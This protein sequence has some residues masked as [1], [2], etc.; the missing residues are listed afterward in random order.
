MF[1]LLNLYTH[2]EVFHVPELRDYIATRD[3]ERNTWPG[4]IINSFYSANN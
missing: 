3:T 2:S 1:E 4:P